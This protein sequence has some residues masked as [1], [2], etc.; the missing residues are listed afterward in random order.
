MSVK[1]HSFP[2]SGTHWLMALLWKNFEVGDC[3][4]A[5]EIPERAGH[6]WASPDGTCPWHHLFGGHGYWSSDVGDVI[7]LARHPY[8]VFRSLYR[9]V[10]AKMPYAEW[11]RLDAKAAG[12]TWI[13]D[14]EVPLPVLWIDHIRS[15]TMRP[16]VHWVHYETLAAAPASTLLKVE[17]QFGLKARGP[18]LDTELPKVG[19]DPC[20]GF[21]WDPQESVQFRQY[22]LQYCPAEVKGYV[23]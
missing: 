11:I 8:S 10:K 22:F 21:A 23:L 15:F 1:V 2:R 13:R 20:P 6:V 16:E 19:W 12:L 14:E 4:N 9:H 18:A 17:R 5:A 7:Y 3:P